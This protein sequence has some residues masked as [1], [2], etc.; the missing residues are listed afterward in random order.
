MIRLKNGKVVLSTSSK[1][2]KHSAY[3]PFWVMTRILEKK[4][5]QPE[6]Q[7]H[8]N[9]IKTSRIETRAAKKKKKKNVQL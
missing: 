8:M 4:I 5:S 6:K 1:G 3:T 7:I 2:S 9:G